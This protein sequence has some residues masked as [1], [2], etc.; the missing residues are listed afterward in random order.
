MA[1]SVAAFQALKPA[2]ASFTFRCR[3]E[4]T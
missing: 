2:V 4:F 3:I 1:L